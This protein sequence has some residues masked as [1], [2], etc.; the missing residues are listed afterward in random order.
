MRGTAIL[1]KEDNT[2]TFIE[3]VELSVYKEIKRQCG[4]EHCNCKLENKVI[5]FG[6]VAPAF[7]HEDE[8]DWD[9]GY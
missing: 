9:Y 1:Y 6:T 7:W 5:D 2:V 4:C 3:D 8:V